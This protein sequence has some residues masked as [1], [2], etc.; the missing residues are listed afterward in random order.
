[1]RGDGSRFVTQKQEEG[2][3]RREIGVRKLTNDGG[4]EVASQKI[5]R[6]E[7]E[8]RLV[9]RE[10]IEDTLE[11]SLVVQLSCLNFFSFI[12]ML[13]RTHRRHLFLPPARQVQGCGTVGVAGVR[14]LGPRQ[15]MIEDQSHHGVMA[16]GSG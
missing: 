7:Q 10:G 15:R 12:F 13:R 1:M 16:L 14:L 8:G 2:E 11:P 3:T 4:K 9:D 5:S 6:R